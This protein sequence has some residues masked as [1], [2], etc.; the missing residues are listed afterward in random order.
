MNTSAVR[1]D[2]NQATESPS[3]KVE[4]A[5]AEHPWVS[6][7]AR[8][9]WIAKGAVYVLMGL[10]AFTI[11]RRRPTTDDASPEGAVAQLRSTQFGTALIW[12]L[13]VGLVLYVAWRLISVALIRGTD[14]KKWL[15]RA[16]YLFSA[17][18]YA[19]LAVTAVT[20]VMKPKD[21]KD[22]NTV[23]RL[24]EWMLGHPV[25]RWA[26]LALGVVVIGVGVFFIV[27]K[28]LKK[29][30]LK[31]LDLSNTPEAERKAITTAGTI[32]WISRGVATAAV[33]FFVA[34]A[35][36]RYS[37]NDARG[38]DNAFRELA[39]H[40]VGSIV[41]L[42]IGLALVVYGVF[43]VLIVRHLDLDKIS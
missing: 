38:F 9:G 36:W 33:G 27:D 10:T 24:S 30:F 11:G 5:V 34:Q 35:A 31:E 7:I 16:G 42:V 2:P 14:G 43:C 20:A 32:G 3:E 8:F 1:I 22:K 37:A 6:R 4:E 17:A 18:F 19:V 28:G 13:V 15:E 23:E 12:A 39:T 29:S 40:Q 21:T 26:L 41:V 25:G